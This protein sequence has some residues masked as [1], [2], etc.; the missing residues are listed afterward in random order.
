MV[1]V[2]GMSLRSTFRA[3]NL[4]LDESLTRG[5]IAS[6]PFQ[7]ATHFGGMLVPES[8]LFLQCFLNSAIEFGWRGGIQSQNWSRLPI[9]NR[10]KYDRRTRSGKSLSAG[11]HFIQQ[12]T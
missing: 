7:V 5:Q 3:D 10:I 6:Q 8:S 2:D 9:Q 11:C 1:N 12:Q 4:R